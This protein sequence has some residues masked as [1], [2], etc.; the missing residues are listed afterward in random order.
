MVLP[1]AAVPCAETRIV[2]RKH[3][4][5]SSKDL[6]LSIEEYAERYIN[7]AMR[8][9]AEGIEAERYNQAILL[10]LSIVGRA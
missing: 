1:L 3:V 7:P 5:W 4:S 2:I 10:Q 6:T 9:L 8:T